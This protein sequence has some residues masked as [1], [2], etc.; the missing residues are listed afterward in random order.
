MGLS[1]IIATGPRQRT[2][3]QAKVPR[4][5]WPHFTLS[6]SRLAQ[7]GGPGPPVRGWPGWTPRHW[8]PFSSPPTAHFLYFFLFLEQKSS[9][10]S[11]SHCDWRS[12]SKSWCLWLEDGSVFC[13]CCWPLLAQSFSSPSPLGLATIFYCL[14]SEASLFVASYNSLGHGG[15]IRPRLHTVFFEPFRGPLICLDADR[16]RNIA[17]N[18]SS[19]VACVRYSGIVSCLHS[20]CLAMVVHMAPVF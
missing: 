1:F 3:S 20:R 16:I 12:V 9:Q 8:V 7:P 15:G 4:G 5:L 2:H 10:N 13:I 18:S 14:R 17:S 11:K 6:D 19:T